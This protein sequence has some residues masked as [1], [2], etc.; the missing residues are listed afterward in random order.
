VDG[1]SRWHPSWSPDGTQ[2]VFSSA[3]AGNL[4]LYV[5]NTDGTDIRQLTGTPIAESLPSWSR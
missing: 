1:Q 5:M 3:K 2:F 4:D